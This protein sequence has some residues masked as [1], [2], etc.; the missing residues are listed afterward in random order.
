MNSSQ[1]RWLLWLT[2]LLGAAWL[3]VFADKSPSGDSA[4]TVARPVDRKPAEAM[5][6]VSA[7]D[8]RPAPAAAP[9][10]RGQLLQLAVRESL[11]RPTPA[12]S[13]DLFSARN[14]TP[15]PPPVEPVQEPVPTAPPLPYTYAGKMHSGGAWEVYLTRGEA[16]Y[17]VRQG[18]SLE[19]TYDIE[20][21][22]PPNMTLK[23]RPL[24]QQQSM[25]IG[26]A[27]Q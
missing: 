18:G 2:M 24:G 6:T 9:P 14:W 21:I 23:Y 26:D 20:K 25:F 11:I 17:I 3:A 27:E 12:S 8:L 22:S 13:V 19:G 10:A 7:Q 4:E 16:T 1:R 15:P 5:A